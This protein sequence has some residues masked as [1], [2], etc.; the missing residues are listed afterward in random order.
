MKIN[1]GVDVVELEACCLL[2]DNI[3]QGTGEVGGLTLRGPNRWVLRI[4]IC[5]SAL[6]ITESFSMLFRASCATLSVRISG[7]PCTIIHWL[8]GTLGWVSLGGP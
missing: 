6:T 7:S 3:P 2:R 5:S 4:A 1:L 8:R